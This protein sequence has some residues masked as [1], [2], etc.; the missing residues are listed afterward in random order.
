MIDLH[1][2]SGTRDQFRAKSRLTIL[3]SHLHPFCSV[4]LDLT[5]RA[6]P[7]QKAKRTAI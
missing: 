1:G 7:E 6:D 5:W 4:T 3:I 2:I